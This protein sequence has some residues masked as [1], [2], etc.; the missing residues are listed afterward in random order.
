MEWTSHAARSS[1]LGLLP[2]LLILTGCSAL[3]GLQSGQTAAESTIVPPAQEMPAET[4]L[5]S[6]SMP[7]PEMPRMASRAPNAKDSPARKKAAAP[8]PKRPPV[9]KLAEPIMPVIIAPA[10][11]VGFD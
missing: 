4:V 6:S 8:P 7:E 10:D 5:Q 2:V 1:V 3:R 9:P 11:L